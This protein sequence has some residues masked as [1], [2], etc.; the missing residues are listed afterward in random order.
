MS[1]KIS[2]ISDLERVLDVFAHQTGRQVRQIYD[3]L[4]E[5]HEWVYTKEEAENLSSRILGVFIAS[6]CGEVE[7]KVKIK[8]GK[9]IPQLSDKKDQETSKYK[10]QGIPKDSN[11]RSRAKTLW[12]IRLSYTHGNGLLNQIDDEALRNCVNDTHLPGVS[13]D[14]GKIILN[15]SVAMASVR[16]IV[17][18]IEKFKKN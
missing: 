12:A 8:F 1:K 17:E 16:T 4:E 5:E 10:F 13:L 3:L 14:S 7:E 15:S 2:K 6:L 9:I 18:I 11:L